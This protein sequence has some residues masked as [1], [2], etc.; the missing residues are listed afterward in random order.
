MK[1]MLIIASALIIISF[2]K[3]VSQN[4]SDAYNF[5]YMNK[6][7]DSSFDSLLFRYDHSQKVSYL[8]L[9]NEIRDSLEVSF[10][11][12][13]I[14]DKNDIYTYKTFSHPV[15]KY[16]SGLEIIKINIKEGQLQL[17]G[18]IDTLEIVGK[19]K[20]KFLAIG[21]YTPNIHAIQKLYLI[22]PEDLSVKLLYDFKDLISW[23]IS[24]GY[25][26]SIISAHNSDRGKK[27]FIETGMHAGGGID[28]LFYFVMDME[29]GTIINETDNPQYRQFTN[30][31]GYALDHFIP[32]VTD[33]FFHV[34]SSS[35]DTT[36]HKSIPKGF[37]LDKDFQVVGRMLP[38]HYTTY[39][40]NYEKGK[41]KSLILGSNTDSLK[42]KYDG[43]QH[44]TFN[45][46]PDYIFEKALYAIYHNQELSQAL[47]DS[48]FRQLDYYQLSILKN[49]VFAK[50]N[51]AFDSEFYQAFFNLFEFYDSEEKRKSRTK[52]INKKLTYSDSQNLE[53]I[54]QA[55]RHRE[56]EKMHKK[57]N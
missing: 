5:Q 36:S 31:D 54:R 22:N 53:K 33:S 21:H 29:K 19:Y 49:M 41:L 56:L 46:I 10:G 26:P 18:K 13:D 44:V 39:G 6:I 43:L 50:H 57:P 51:Y 47:Y 34:L 20:D 55:L 35:W 40:Y 14:V 30:R 52:D 42:S 25:E 8:I 11:K 16:C 27:L 23:N 3:L 17:I 28:D 37:I 24:E 45:Y 48:E 1:K 9:N 38:K 7:S 15:R 4:I 12:D 32:D 2:S